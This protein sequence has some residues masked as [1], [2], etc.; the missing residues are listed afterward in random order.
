M[1][2]IKSILAIPKL[3]TILNNIYK[4]MDVLAH[5]IN[6]TQQKVKLIESDVK[7]ILIDTENE[8]QI[9]ML[10]ERITIIEAFFDNLEEISTEDKKNLAN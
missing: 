5:A 10:N 1:K 7:K 2:L 3:I 8:K 6:Q 9:R 4:Q